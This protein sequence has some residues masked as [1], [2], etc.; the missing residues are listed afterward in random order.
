M[1]ISDRSAARAD[2]AARDPRE[3][4]RAPSSR[5]LWRVPCGRGLGRAHKGSALRKTIAPNFPR[6][7]VSSR[8]TSR[9]RTM[10]I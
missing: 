5:E 10:P 8:D 6:I 1:K 7:E 9:L 3:Y 4:L 2:L